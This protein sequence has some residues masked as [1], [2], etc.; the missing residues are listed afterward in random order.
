MAS[1]E[2]LKR[3]PYEKSYSSLCTKESLSKKNCS[4][5]PKL[6]YSC[7]RSLIT[8]THYCCGKAKELPIPFGQLAVAIEK[9]TGS[10]MLPVIVSVEGQGLHLL[11]FADNQLCLIGGVAEYILPY[12][13]VLF[14]KAQKLED[15]SMQIPD[16]VITTVDKLSVRGVVGSI[17]D[18]WVKYEADLKNQTDKVLGMT[19][20]IPLLSPIASVLNALVSPFASMVSN[21]MLKHSEAEVKEVFS[22]DNDTKAVIEDTHDGSE[23]GSVDDHIFLGKKEPLVE[24]SDAII[25]KDEQHFDKMSQEDE[26]TFHEAD[27]RKGVLAP[28]KVSDTSADPI[29]ELFDTSWHMK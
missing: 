26:K 9:T 17:A 22:D 10:W 23:H 8:I 4:P 21:W 15:F 6:F 3:D 1:S 24:T 16:I 2:Q 29:I 28:I 18:L 7:G 19:Q 20:K 14:E 13:S 27:E 5:R 12:I 25:S 11:T